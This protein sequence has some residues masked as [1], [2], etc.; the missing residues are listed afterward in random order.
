MK[1]VPMVV[2]AMKYCVHPACQAPQN[3]DNESHCQNCGSGLRLYDRYRPIKMIGQGG[4][5]RTFLAIDENS[6][7][8]RYRL[9]KQFYTQD[10]TISNGPINVRNDTKIPG[11]NALEKIPE[12]FRKEVARLEQ[13]GKHPQI[14]GLLDGFDQDHFLYLVQEYFDGKNLA[15]EL[16]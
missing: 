10:S 11:G 13:L 2:M 1:N 8:R 7:S 5:G 3:Y 6:P 14:P 12:I 15:T 4:F 9:V 16:E